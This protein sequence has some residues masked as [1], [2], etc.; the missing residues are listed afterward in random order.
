MRR[1]MRFYYKQKLDL[2]SQVTQATQKFRLILPQRC[3]YLGDFGIP[4]GKITNVHLVVAVARF[5]VL[6]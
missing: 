4:L 6:H 3:H 5:R 1:A 2:L